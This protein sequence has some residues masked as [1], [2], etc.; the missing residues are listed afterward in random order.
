MIS[1]LEN[2]LIFQLEAQPA[3]LDFYLS[4]RIT[5]EGKV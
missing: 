4:L 1:V 3:V 5:P 2:V